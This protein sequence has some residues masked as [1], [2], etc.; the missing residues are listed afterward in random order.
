MGR[1][2]VSPASAVLAKSEDWLIAREVTR[3]IPPPER[4]AELPRLTAEAA[5]KRVRRAV[6]P[7]VAAAV[8]QAC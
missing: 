3:R 6:R 2:A 8:A 5:R 7:Q 1:R 4:R